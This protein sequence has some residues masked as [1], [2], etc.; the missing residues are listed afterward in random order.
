LSEK[1]LR[2]DDARGWKEHIYTYSIVG[3]SRTL[4]RRI[5]LI[6]SQFKKSTDAIVFNLRQLFRLQSGDIGIR[7]FYHHHDS[8]IDP[9]SP[10]LL[11]LFNPVEA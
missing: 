3:V 7:P 11:S 1:R 5:A 4:R 10:R 8:S 9:D 2:E 6:G